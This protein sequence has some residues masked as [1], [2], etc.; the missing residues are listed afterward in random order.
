M[1]TK[2]LGVLQ[3]GNQAFGSSNSVVGT[4]LSEFFSVVGTK[5]GFGASHHNNFHTFNVMNILHY[6]NYTLVTPYEYYY[7]C[8]V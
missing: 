3:C 1:E 8:L 5:Q 2:H 6:N 4:K 7:H